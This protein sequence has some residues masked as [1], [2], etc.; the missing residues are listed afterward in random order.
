M[1]CRSL[2][3]GGLTQ[4]I[5]CLVCA[6][7][8]DSSVRVGGS[9]DKNTYHPSVKIRVQIN[10]TLIKVGVGRDQREFLRQ[11]CSEVNKKHH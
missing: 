1:S 11:T 6:I 10:R 7:S 4:E 9:L 5:A 2:I 8:R 3:I